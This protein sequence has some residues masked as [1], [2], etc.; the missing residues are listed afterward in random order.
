MAPN[1]F[2]PAAAEEKLQRIAALQRGHTD[3]GEEAE[4]LAILARAGPAELDHML[5][6]LSLGALIDDL[7]DRPFGPRHKSELLRLLCQERIGD[8]SV[9]VRAALIDALQRGPTGVRDE[10][11]IGQVFSRTAGADLR[12]L[13][14]AVDAGD[15]YHHLHQLIYHDL[16][17]DELRGQLLAHI[18]R[19]AAA[20]PP[21]PG[22]L[23]VLSDIDDTFF[24]NWVDARYPKKT[25][26]PGVRAFYR[27]LDQVGGRLGDLVFVTAR[28]FDRG[29][30]SESMTRKT[31][32][33]R[34]VSECVVLTGEFS[35]LLTNE[36][37]AQKKVER[38]REYQALFP[39]YG[40]VFL[41][42]SGQGDVLAGAQM[43][44]HGGAHGGVR[45]VFIHDVVQTPEAERAAQRARR[46]YF[47]DTYVGAAADAGAL[48]LLDAPAMARVA[49]AAV[50]EMLAVPFTDP[51]QREERFAAL[52][53]DLSRL[54]ALLPEGARI[55][56]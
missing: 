17:S 18:A 39:E 32:R 33:E 42:D 29:G 19:E 40:Y 27:E 22:E 21:P 20:A 38:F 11:A 47:H 6:R 36:L 37:I 15:D 16:D 52:R 50:D 26:Y 44:A 9:P 8:L 46:I 7:D 56:L 23:K 45:A 5:S 41:G 54:N 10:A 25:V 55:G 34:G 14:N 3:R 1:P 35:H 53:H 28:P 49:R 43:L 12:A 4:I 24:C 30:V 51:K 31:L 48:G 2:D 13:K